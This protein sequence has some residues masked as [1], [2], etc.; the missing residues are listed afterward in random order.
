M[1]YQHTRRAGQTK[2]NIQHKESLCTMYAE[3]FLLQ[4]TT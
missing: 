3:V 1:Q 2:S 4:I